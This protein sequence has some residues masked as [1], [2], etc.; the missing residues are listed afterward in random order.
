MVLKWI[1]IIS[2]YIWGCVLFVFLIYIHTDKSNR[3]SIHC[4]S[5]PIKMFWCG[6]KVWI[7]TVWLWMLCACQ[8]YFIYNC[9]VFGLLF[10]ILHRL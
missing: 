8:M 2:K 4:F 3:H 5:H 1:L 7:L 9:N 6:N 10:I